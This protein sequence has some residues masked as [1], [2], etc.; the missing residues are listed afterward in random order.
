MILR[1]KP[2]HHSCYS[3]LNSTNRPFLSHNIAPRSLDDPTGQGA[4][5]YMS[6]CNNN[7]FEGESEACIFN[8]CS[9][10]YSSVANQGAVLAISENSNASGNARSQVEVNQCLV[11]GSSCGKVSRWLMPS[12]QCL[13]GSMELFYEVEVTCSEYS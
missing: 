1:E 11:V 2:T 7:G 10:Y 13:E 4:D 6:A 3:N 12:N 8:N 9:F 5:V